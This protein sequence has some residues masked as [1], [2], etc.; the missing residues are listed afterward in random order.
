MLEI[1]RLAATGKYTYVELAAKFGF[2]TSQISSIV[3]G[4]SW[5]HLPFDGKRKFGNYGDR[6]P[7]AKLSEDSVREIRKLHSHGKCTQRQLADLF[8][9]SEITIW[10]AINRTQWKHVF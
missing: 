10:R 4:R 7:F 2:S 6:H 3:L 9:V 1:R 5:K 8:G